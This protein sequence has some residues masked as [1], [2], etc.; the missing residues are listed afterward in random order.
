VEGFEELLGIL[1][2]LLVSIGLVDETQSL[3]QDL[4]RVRQDLGLKF[5]VEHEFLQD[6][7]CSFAEVSVAQGDEEVALHLNHDL[8]PV[9]QVLLLEGLLDCSVEDLNV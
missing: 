2:A 3:D 8:K 1:L 9:I 6:S 4:L 5:R 7:N